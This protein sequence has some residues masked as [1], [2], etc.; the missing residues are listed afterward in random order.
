MGNH[1]CL[2]LQSIAWT[3]LNQRPDE[4]T[5]YLTLHPKMKNMEERLKQITDP[6]AKV[7]AEADFKRYKELEPVC[8]N[9]VIAYKA[10]EAARKERDDA[11]ATL[12]AAEAQ[13]QKL[14]E[15]EKHVSTLVSD[16]H[17]IADEK[18]ITLGTL[19]PNVTGM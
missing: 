4:F 16:D 17:I 8:S 6:K 10:L 18:H 3:T 15:H 2:T 5:E 7:K 13:F 1:F 19:Y 14:R 11:R 9:L 12:V